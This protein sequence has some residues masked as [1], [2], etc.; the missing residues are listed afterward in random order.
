MN[1]TDKFDGAEFIHKVQKAQMF[2]KHN[3]MDRGSY[4][5][6]IIFS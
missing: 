3:L 5:Q 2:Q 6:V 1:L 4:H